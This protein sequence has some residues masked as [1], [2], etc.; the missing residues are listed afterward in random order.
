MHQVYDRQITVIERYGLIVA[1]QAIQNP[2]ARLSQETRNE[3]F[4][5][6][7]GLQG[8]KTTREVSNVGLVHVK[9]LSLLISVLNFVNYIF[10]ESID[11]NT[12]LPRSDSCA[13]LLLNTSSFQIQ[14]LYRSAESACNAS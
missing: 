1:G 9:A 8:S 3:T 6:L 13:Q 7:Y 2:K 11:T 4:C 12:L 5:L 10:S 14:T